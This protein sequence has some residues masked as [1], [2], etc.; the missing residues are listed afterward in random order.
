[1]QVQRVCKIARL[2]VPDPQ[3]PGPLFFITRDYENYYRLH[4]IAKG[5]KTIIQAFV[6]C[7]RILEN[8]PCG[9]ILLIKYLALKSSLKF[10][11]LLIH[12]SNKLKML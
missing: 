8:H 11:F 2:L 5:E 12:C 4:Y 1:M 6:I 10:Y 3:S 9:H 7:D